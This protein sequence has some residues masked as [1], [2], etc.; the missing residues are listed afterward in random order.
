[1]WKG[2]VGWKLLVT[3][4]GCW[5][6]QVGW[7][8]QCPLE[9]VDWALPVQYKQKKKKQ[10]EQKHGL[11]FHSGA[12]S[13]LGLASG[14]LWQNFIAATISFQLNNKNYVHP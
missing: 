2:Q 10:K 8:T 3:W 9:S 1:M 5:P 13:G 6:W 11:F 4:Q 7:G 12:W 14:R